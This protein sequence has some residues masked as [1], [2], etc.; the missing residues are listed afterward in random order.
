MALAPPSTADRV[1]TFDPGR[2][3]G[4]VPGQD[5]GRG[6][7]G[8]RAGRAAP[9]ARPNPARAAAARVVRTRGRCVPGGGAVPG[10]ERGPRMRQLRHSAVA[11]LGGQQVPL[12]LIMAKTR[13]RSPRTAMRYV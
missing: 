9:S 2:V 8:R 7:C 1:T 12:E 6:G 5:R 10:P 4:T 13:H 11:R 3:V